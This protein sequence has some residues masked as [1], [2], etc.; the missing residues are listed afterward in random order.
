MSNVADV[1]RKQLPAR[2]EQVSRIHLLG[3]ML[4]QLTHMLHRIE[5]LRD[6][7]ADKRKYRELL[8]LKGQAEAA[9]TRLRD[10]LAKHGGSQ[11]AKG[12]K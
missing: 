1:A 6:V 7:I 12:Y 4:D 11:V 9:V 8:E 2:T 5:A 3:L 10:A